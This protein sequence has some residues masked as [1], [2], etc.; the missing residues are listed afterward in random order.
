MSVFVS[1]ESCKEIDNHDCLGALQTYETA[2]SVGYYLYVV[3]TFTL[4]A[5]LSF[6]LIGRGKDVVLSSANLL[7]IGI[8]S[9]P[10]VAAYFANMVSTFAVL[11]YVASLSAGFLLAS[12]GTKSK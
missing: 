11:I 9:V 3:L 10:Y 1:L 2:Y 4:C 12:Y 5:Y 6:K 7:A 8:Y